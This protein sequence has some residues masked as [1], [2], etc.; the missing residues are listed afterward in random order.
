MRPRTTALI[1]WLCILLAGCGP[2]TAD[3][4]AAAA[5]R[6]LAGLKRSFNV[7]AQTKARVIE[8]NLDD[9]V[10]TI[11]RFNRDETWQ[12]DYRY[13]L[14]ALRLV[15]KQLRE[16]PL[17]APELQPVHSALLGAATHCEAVTNQIGIWAL[18]LQQKKPEAAQLDLRI[19]MML[20]RDCKTA[21]ATV[22]QET[23]K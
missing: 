3:I 17:P 2:S 22:R 4:R 14:A 13:Q 21:L 18:S 9:L 20:A 7:S 5:A 11:M 15:T 1:L 6:S 12:K 16:T 8:I 19:A 10:K 23:A